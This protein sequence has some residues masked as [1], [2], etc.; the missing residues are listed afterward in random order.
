M[1][2]NPRPKS[3]K[4]V[5]IGAAYWKDRNRQQWELLTSLGGISAMVT[6]LSTEK[7]IDLRDWCNYYLKNGHCGKP[8]KEQGVKEKRNANN[9]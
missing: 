5:L 4:K 9:G 2:T 6:D 1:P 3:G 7:I 8:I